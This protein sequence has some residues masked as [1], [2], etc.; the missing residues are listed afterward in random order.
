MKLI[1]ENWRKFINEEKNS[2]IISIKVVDY[3]IN[4]IKILTNNWDMHRLFDQPEHYEKHAGFPA[5]QNFGVH[6]VLKQSSD[7]STNY[8]FNKIKL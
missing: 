2:S 5:T 7:L 8:K 1:I 6:R 4:R 3:L